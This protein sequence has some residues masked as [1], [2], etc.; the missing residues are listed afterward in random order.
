MSLQYMTDALSR[1]FV[2]NGLTKQPH[3]H[4]VAL[5]GNA[6]IKAG[7]WKQLLWCRIVLTLCMSLGD[8]HIHSGILHTDKVY[9]QMHI[10]HT[11]KGRESESK[12][13]M[14]DS[15]CTNKKQLSS[16]EALR[17]KSWNGTCRHKSSCTQGQANQKYTQVN[18][19]KVC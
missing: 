6:G 3:R 1:Q 10:S 15:Q 11:H 2:S 7:S 5:R 12:Y 9:K 16:I 4:L 17:D 18:Q 14:E 13:L 19:T 8:I